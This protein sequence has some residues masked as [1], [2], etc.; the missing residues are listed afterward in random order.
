ML[1]LRHKVFQVDPNDPEPLR[2]GWGPG[3][4]GALSDLRRR[5]TDLRGWVEAFG[6]EVGPENV[7]SINEFGFPR[8]TI[9][10]W[11]REEVAAEAKPAGAAVDDEYFATAGG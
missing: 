2:M 4:P 7:V 10:V 11:Y 3:L 1:A 5:L 6:N 9:T 8:Y